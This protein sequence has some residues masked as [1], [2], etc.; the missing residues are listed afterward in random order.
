[1]KIAKVEF[2]NE[3]NILYLSFIV[4]TNANTENFAKFL[5]LTLRS[6]CAIDVTVKEYFFMHVLVEKYALD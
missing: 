2:K 3:R 5:K 4:N 1:M 6:I